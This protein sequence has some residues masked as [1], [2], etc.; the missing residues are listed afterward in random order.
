ML[1]KI[2]TNISNI[3]INGGYKD[4]PYSDKD[5]IKKIVFWQNI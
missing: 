2:Q 3:T 1:R 5:N 4:N